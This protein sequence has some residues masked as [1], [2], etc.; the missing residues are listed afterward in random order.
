MTACYSHHERHPADTTTC[1][2]KRCRWIG[3]RPSG[4]VAAVA[5]AVAGYS[6]STSSYKC[7]SGAVKCT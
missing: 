6:L 2:R 5:V 1:H 7:P 4:S 3:E